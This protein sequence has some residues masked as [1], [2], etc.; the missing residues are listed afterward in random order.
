MLTLDALADIA[1]RHAFHEGLNETVIPGLAVVRFSHPTLTDFAVHPPSVCIVAQ[2]AKRMTVGNRT[3]DY[4][5]SK[6][7]VVSVDLPMS[8]RIIAATP[9]APYLC[10]RIALDAAAIAGLLTEHE[11]TSPDTE[12]TSDGLYI[13]ETA[14]EI[15]DAAL[16]V[17]R[18]LDRGRDDVLRTIAERELFYCLL[19]GR[20]GHT[21]R[22][23]VIAGSAMH[24]VNRAIA[25]LK[26][27]FTEPLRIPDLAQHASMSASS[28][29]M[30][31]KRVTGMSPLQ[32]QKQLR[33]Q[34]ARQL[35]LARD[36]GAATAGFEVGYE[37][38]TQ[39][40]REYRRLFGQPPARDVAEIRQRAVGTP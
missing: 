14:P 16:R 27:R 38:P 37:S 11:I 28:L 13:D 39:F 33:L 9:E 7:V 40:S 30:H 31:F 3:F 24:R 22:Q 15:A 32:F 8:A 6:Y 17:A 36:C 23:L 34:H 19:R 2:G 26:A 29:H 35:M 1:L 25:W 5:A 20:H 4:N 10:W 21:V 12:H 18:Q